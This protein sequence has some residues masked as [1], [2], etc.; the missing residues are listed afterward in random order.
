TLLKLR[1]MRPG[2]GRQVTA[3]GDARVTRVGRFLRRTKLDELPQ[4]WNVLRG[5][6]ALVGARPEVPAFVDGRDP[7]WTRV[8]LVRPGLTDPVSVR[9][10]DEEDLLAAAP[11]PDEFYVRTLQPWKL[12]GYA[13]YQ[14]ARTWQRDLEVLARTAVVALRPGA[15]RRADL[16]DILGGGPPEGAR[17]TGAAGR[18]Q[19][20]P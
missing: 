2:A 6:M 16:G 10:R 5:D 20:A 11:D 8:L 17:E 4:L 12:R 1:T 18:A 9:L 13:A 3:R 14:E 7:L 15:A 19:R